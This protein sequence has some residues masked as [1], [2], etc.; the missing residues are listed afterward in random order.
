MAETAKKPQKDRA[1]EQIAAPE[2]RSA[3]KMAGSSGMWGQCN[4]LPR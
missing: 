4:S 2:P 1:N 3:R